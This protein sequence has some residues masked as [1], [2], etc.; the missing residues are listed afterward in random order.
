MEITIAWY[1][2]NLKKQK[3]MWSST[4]NWKKTKER[5]SIWKLKERNS[6]RRRFI[7][8]IYRWDLIDY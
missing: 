2:Q 7:L 5:N 8:E 4:L 6:M 3:S 1:N